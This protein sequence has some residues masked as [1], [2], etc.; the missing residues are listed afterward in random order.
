MSDDESKQ[1]REL[2]GSLLQDEPP[3]TIDSRELVRKGRRHTVVI[4]TASIGTVALT[5]V[6]VV[7]LTTL[8]RP[9]AD[10]STAIP[11]ASS[12]PSA[13]PSPAGAC[14]MFTEDQRSHALTRALQ[15]SADKFIPAGQTAKPRP[16]SWFGGTDSA[17]K[18]IKPVNP[19]M[20]RP[21]WPYYASAD[22]GNDKDGFGSLDV[23]IS[24]KGTNGRCTSPSTPPLTIVR[25]VD[26]ADTTL[27]DGTY[28]AL[29]RYVGGGD[30]P[31]TSDT[32]Y[33]E[34]A[35]DAVRPDG[36]RVHVVTSNRAP[37]TLMASAPARPTRVEPPLSSKELYTIVELPGVKY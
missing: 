37:A 17:L 1:A 33:K 14:P 15:E 35:V 9:T 25:L 31:V 16:A 20:L 30:G 12:T 13:C 28:A 34:L 2:L 24:D 22:V 29:S 32:G 23:Y 4:R 7:F 18:V 21:Q 6:G 3:V 36:T 19:S 8:V 27:P 5:V 26:C 11:A 10:D